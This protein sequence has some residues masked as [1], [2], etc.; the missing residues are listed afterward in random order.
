[1]KLQIERKDAS[2]LGI[3]V[4]T[5]PI[6]WVREERKRKGGEVFIKGER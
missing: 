5:I 4:E 6:R 3:I 1:L 2:C